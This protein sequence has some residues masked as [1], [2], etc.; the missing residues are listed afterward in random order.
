MSR[1]TVFP[2]RDSIEKRIGL[3]YQRRAAGAELMRVLKKYG[4]FSQCAMSSS[5]RAA[6]ERYPTP[7]PERQTVR[8]TSTPVLDASRYDLE[9]LYLHHANI[10]ELIRS[11]KNYHRCQQKPGR[12]L[13]P[14]CQSRI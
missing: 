7:A 5:P 1:V 4:R 14:F 12:R 6:K 9:S 10:N 2:V 3:L 11:L 8:C 13:R